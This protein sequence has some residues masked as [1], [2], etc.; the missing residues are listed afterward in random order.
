MTINSNEVFSLTESVDFSTLSRW[1]CH[2][3]RVN[4]MKNMTR[5]EL[6]RRRLIPPIPQAIGSPAA[7]VE[8]PAAEAPPDAEM[9]LD[10]ENGAETG[11]ESFS[12]NE[13][14]EGPPEEIP[15]N[16]LFSNDALIL[17]M[18]SWFCLRSVAILETQI[19]EDSVR[20]LSIGTPFHIKLL[21]FV[22]DQLLI[23]ISL[24]HWLAT[25][26]AR[27]RESCP[28]VPHHLL[29]AMRR[30]LT[31]RGTSVW[32]LRPEIV[33]LLTCW[34]KIPCAANKCD[35]QWVFYFKAMWA[36]KK[37]CSWRPE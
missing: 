28:C 26:P 36:P 33:R 24:K 7:G 5:S 12:E 8:Q 1:K 15:W 29:E 22:A 20:L 10:D 13:G 3:E 9:G 18:D 17:R 14:L 4:S 27:V 35:E 11:S 25:E 19:Y 6:S 37:T 31:L 32:P 23:L 30:A 34:L 2:P 16:L 21:R